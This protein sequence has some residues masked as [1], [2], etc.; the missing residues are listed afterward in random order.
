MTCT[1]TSLRALASTHLLDSDQTLLRKLD[2]TAR[3]HYCPK[4]LL[5]EGRLLAGR[6][7][8]AVLGDLDFDHRDHIDLLFVG[9]DHLNDAR[10]SGAR[11]SRR[12]PLLL[13]ALGTGHARTPS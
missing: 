2:T 9:R 4:A 12:L 8:I 10:T 13:R 6:K 5:P 7:A 3:R 1:L 11:C